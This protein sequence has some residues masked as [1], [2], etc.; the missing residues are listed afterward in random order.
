MIKYTKSRC[1]TPGQYAVFYQNDVC[2]GGGVIKQTN[3]NNKQ[4]AF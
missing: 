1:V 2:I 3:A 4:L